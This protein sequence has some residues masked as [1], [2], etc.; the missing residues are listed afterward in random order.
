MA[1][2]VDKAIMT[3]VIAHQSFRG[4]V[5]AFAVTAPF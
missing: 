1:V 2:A 5:V 3:G 4:I